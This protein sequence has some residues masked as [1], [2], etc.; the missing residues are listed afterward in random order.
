LIDK[1][2]L[3]SQLSVLHAA[4]AIEEY[5]VKFY[6]QLEGCI[7]EENGKALMRGLA[8][9]EM[10]HGKLIDREIERLSTGHD[11]SGIGPD[12]HYLDI[13]P[14][15]VFESFPTDRCLTIKEEMTALEIGIEVEKRSVK[16]YQEAAK[17]TSDPDVKMKFDQLTKMEQGHLS[18]LI[19]NLQLLKDEGTWY[20]YSPILEG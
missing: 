7:A 15:K 1:A 8:R 14:R 9:D 5:G 6:Q 10:S 12:H 19:D 17:N 18:L 13:V 4:L 11:V 16:M 20:G 3:R 2:S